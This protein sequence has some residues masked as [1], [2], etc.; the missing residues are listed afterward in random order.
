M[1]SAISDYALDLG[2]YALDLEF[3]RSESESQLSHTAKPPDDPRQGMSGK[4]K[5]SQAQLSRWQGSAKRHI[6]RRK[7]KQ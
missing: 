3:E 4:N 6:A 2:Q 7:A 5:R 1:N